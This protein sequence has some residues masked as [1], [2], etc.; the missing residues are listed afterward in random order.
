MQLIS[1][2]KRRTKYLLC[3]IHM[4]TKY[5]WVV[6]LKDKKGVTVVNAFQN[7]LDNSKRKPN[8]IWVDQGNEFYKTSFKKWLNGNGIEMYSAYN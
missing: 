5:A 7:I 4:F 8:K 1:K 3:V 6:S 2:Y